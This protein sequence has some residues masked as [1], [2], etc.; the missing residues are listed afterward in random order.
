MTEDL[1]QAAPALK[2]IFD[3]DRLRHIATET[4]SISPGF[5]AERFMMLATEGLDGLGI[6]QRL[7]Q[8]ATSLN[9]CLAGSFEDAVAVLYD[10]APR[11][12]HGFASIVLPEFVA[13]YGRADFDRSMEALHYF[14]RFG[15]AEFAIRHFLADD[16]DRTIKVM[17]G[18]AL[19]DNEHVRRLASEGSRPRLPWSFQ[20]KNLVSDPSP[21]LPILEA[22]RAD[23]SLYVRK[24]VA[25]HLNDIS[26]D[27]PGRLLERLAGWDMAD[28]NTAWI[29]RHALRTLIKKGDP[30]ALDLIGTTGKPKVDVAAFAVTPASIALGGRIALKTSIVSTAQ[31]PQQLVVDYAVHYV[32]KAGGTSKKVFKLK[33]ITLPPAG[34]KELSISQAVRDFTTRKHYPGHHRIELIV[35]GETVAEGGFELRG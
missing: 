31:E 35:N 23:P 20:M 1:T 32:K 19:D 18:W 25:N 4:A 11:I 26:K 33:E 30:Q 10:L 8:T 2:E 17:R 22:L 27:N 21:T 9:G 28:R 24:S 5:D 16:F 15:S 7:R 13:L 34:Q 3:R 6:M 29:V 14:T 12:Q